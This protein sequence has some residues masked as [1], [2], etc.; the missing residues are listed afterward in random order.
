MPSTFAW[1]AHDDQEAQRVREALAAF[2]EQ[3]MQDP[4]G[5]GP[6]RDAFSEMLF[7]GTSTV[8]T[9]ARYFVLIPWIYRSLDEDGVAPAVGAARARERELAL[10]E[11][12]LRGSADHDGII[13][14]Q[15]RGD[16][17]QLP[18]AV[19]WGGLGRWGI[20]RFPGTRAE[21]VATLARRRRRHHDDADPDATEWTGAW[22]PALPSAPDHWL[23]Q[24]SI[25]LTTDEADFLRTRILDSTRGSY[26]AHLA[27]D[28]TPGGWP[29]FPWDHPVAATASPDVR[30][31]LMHARLFSLVQHGAALRYNRE[32]SALLEA[33]GFDPLAADYHAGLEGWIDAMDAH[34][35]LLH[36]WDR[37]DLW[38]TVHE[39]NPRLS[40]TVRAFADWWFDQAVDDPQTAARSA[41]VGEQ[42]RQREATIKG[43]RAKLA[44]RRARERSPVAQGGGRLAFRWPQVRRILDD[45]LEAVT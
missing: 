45:I 31:Q 17:R 24:T 7:P 16:T 22:H 20:R 36:S 39:Q 9:R 12:L 44:N 29:D 41:P 8:H 2:D 32:L 4:L 35:E 3:G 25:E 26:L 37:T 5:F 13:G 28:A 33:D 11:S 1:I 38:S 10:I 34:A 23:E 21:Y 30:R 14:R 42:L 43:A 18:S 40:A 6:I 19:Y 15:S 27:R